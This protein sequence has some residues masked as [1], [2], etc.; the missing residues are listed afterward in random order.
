MIR[1]NVWDVIESS[2]GDMVYFAD[3]EAERNELYETINRNSKKI[4]KLK[5]ENNQLKT[6]VADLKETNIIQEEEILKLIGHNRE[7]LEILNNTLKY[8]CFKGWGMTESKIKSL[9]E[10]VEGE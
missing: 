9:I 2:T 3:H 5:A 6:D 8:G 1:Y 4:I 10:K 7:M